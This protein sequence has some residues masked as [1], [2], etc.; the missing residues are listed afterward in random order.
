[1]E[2]DII[3]K[4]DNKE[5]EDEREL[6]KIISSKHPGDT[7]KFTVVRGD[8]KLQISVTLGERPKEGDLSKIDTKSEEFDIIGLKV[9]D[10]DDGKGVK[11]VSIKNG[12]SAQSNG[13]RVND[14]ILKIGRE[15]IVSKDQYNSLISEYE[16]SEVIMLKIVRNG[17]QGVYAFTIN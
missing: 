14:I 3:V 9:S 6:I 16:A 4:V 11:I 7:A 17:N 1:M 13:F 5:I 2:D 10:T 8:E 12:S 15:S